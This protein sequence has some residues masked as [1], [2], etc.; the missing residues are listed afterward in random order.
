MRMC[1]D[2]VVRP[3]RWRGRR[4]DSPWASCFHSPIRPGGVLST[5]NLLKC[6]WHFAQGVKGGRA[7]KKENATQNKTRQVKNHLARPFIEA[8]R[9][10]LT[11]V[12]QSR[13]L[14]RC[15]CGTPHDGGGWTSPRARS[16]N[17]VRLGCGNQKQ[18]KKKKF[19]RMDG[20]QSDENATLADTTRKPAPSPFREKTTSVQR[21]HVSFVRDE[22]NVRADQIRGEKGWEARGCALAERGA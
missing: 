4:P 10:P 19:E 22:E 1:L 9:R 18:G 6:D 13:T 20:E 16:S 8:K 14:Y 11:P 17:R 2:W 3:C 5:G 12:R 7:G 21:Q 15:L